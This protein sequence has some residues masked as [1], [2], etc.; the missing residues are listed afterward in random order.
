MP[1]SSEMLTRLRALLG[2]AALQAAISQEV[3]Q[4]GA[5]RMVAVASLYARLIAS[6]SDGA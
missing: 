4:T 2:H 3:V 5:R 1:T 6:T